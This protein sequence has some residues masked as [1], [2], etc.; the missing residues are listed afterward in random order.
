[1]SESEQKLFRPE[2]FQTRNAS[3]LGRPTIALGLPMTVSTGMSLVLAAA[4]AALVAF[5]SYTRRV[6]LTGVMLPRSG[7]VAVSVPA[8]GWVQRLAVQEGDTVKEG[9]LLYTL[10]LDTTIKRGGVQQ[11]II[12]ALTVQRGMLNDEITR[13][14]SIAAETANR[15]AQ[16]IT[17]FKAQLAQ[18]AEQIKTQ[19]SFEKTS[20]SFISNR[21]ATITFPLTRWTRVSMPGWRPNPRSSSCSARASTCKV[22]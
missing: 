14:Q 17:N 19:A 6:N 9:T 22:S 2:S 18:L 4:L 7:L 5:S 15:L 3:W 8:A 21:L 20:T 11:A 16:T 13:R 12:D 10:E 1:M